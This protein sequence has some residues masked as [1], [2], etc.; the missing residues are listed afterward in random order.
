MWLILE[1][2]LYLRW[3]DDAIQ[4]GRDPIKSRGISSV[5]QISNLVINVALDGLTTNSAKPSVGTV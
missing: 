1:A 3:P 4:N 5:K 2:L